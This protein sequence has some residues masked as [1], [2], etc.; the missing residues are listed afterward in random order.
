MSFFASTPKQILSGR[1]SARSR[2]L[3]RLEALE[4]RV[5]PWATSGNL[6]PTPSLITLSF[7]PD[8]TDLGGMPS[9]LFSSMNAR[10]GSPTAWQAQILKAAQVWAKNTNINFAV[11]SDNGAPLGSGAYQ[12]GDPGFGDIRIGGYNFENSSLAMAYSPPPINNYSIAGDIQFNTGQV[13]NIGATYDLFT[14]AMHEFGH[15]LTMSHSSVLTASEYLAY[16]SV[17]TGLDWDDI[18]GIRSAYSANQPR[19]HDYNDTY[20]NNNSFWT[21]T[22]VTQHLQSDLTLLRHDR[23]ITTTSDVDYFKITA[24]SWFGS[25]VQ[26]SAQSNG[27][28]L[29]APNIWVYNSS[30]Q[31][32]GYASG[33]GQYGTT[34]TVT[35][36]NQISAGQVIYVKVDGSDSTPFGTGKYAL[37]M[38]W[39]SAPLPTQAPPV[40]TMANG[41]PLSGGGGIA[42]ANSQEIVVAAPGGMEFSLNESSQ[43][44]AMDRQGNYVVTWSARNTQTG[45]R[46]II[47][48][49]LDAAGNPRR[50]II[51]V[52]SSNSGAQMYPAVAMTDSGEFLITWAAAE[53]GGGGWDIWARRF[54][55]AGNPLGTDFQVNEFTSGDQLYPT[56]AINAPGDFVITWSSQQQDGSGWGI[57]GR[58]YTDAVPGREY[59]VNSTKWSDQKWSRVAMDAAGNFVVTW[60]SQQS[61][62]G[63]DVYA[64]GF[65]PTGL[66]LTTEFRVNQ[67]TSDDQ[68]YSALAMDPSGAF[69]V[70][71]QSHGQDGDDW[72]IYARSF[73]ALGAAATDEFRVNTTVLGDQIDATVAMSQE[74]DF[75][76]AWSGDREGGPLKTPLHHGQSSGSG[77]SGSGSSGSGSSGSGN[78]GSDGSGSGSSGSG[79]SGPGS[80]GPS[81]YTVVE[82]L[83]AVYAQQY[84]HGEAVGEEFRVN[85]SA[86]GDHRNASAAMN[87]MGVIAV[88]WGGASISG[89]TF[90]M[91]QM[92]AVGAEEMHGFEEHPME[93]KLLRASDP[94]SAVALAV[95]I[96][97]SCTPTHLV[98][99]LTPS[100]TVASTHGEIPGRYQQSAIPA[101]PQASYW[102]LGRSSGMD[103][104][105]LPEAESHA[106]SHELLPTATEPVVAPGEAFNEGT[107]PPAPPAVAGPSE[108]IVSALPDSGEAVTTLHSAS[109][110]YTFFALAG[111]VAPF[112]WRRA[113]RKRD[114]NNRAPQT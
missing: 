10:F 21:A 71:W 66:P 114:R 85:T 60:S 87:S 49:L 4:S 25:T 16:T 48:L 83:W 47:A 2:F 59:R 15:A 78:S 52:S 84:R 90:T 82:S 11:V 5:V 29:L 80:S 22:D 88:A 7:V 26:F 12:Q 93:K 55:A 103:G 19:S 33:A 72:D 98:Q 8:G 109:G 51:T 99:P 42:N 18:F 96:P 75:I 35:L 70:A 100:S 36:T 62:N 65:G 45:E 57:Y 113:E 53:P 89:Q 92:Y 74:G 44:V 102:Q 17:K 13:F 6:W 101:M 27:L 79:N 50:D 37:A 95:T 1:W 64:R 94:P 68:Q 28:S 30:F 91:A 32:I 110:C 9:N 23:D 43:S 104:T 69:V 24:P 20:G 111:V 56:A 41:T 97:H 31:Q 61:G 107:I 63:W 38:R 77:S 46:F 14:V 39:A 106:P 105:E 58:S 54:D 73:A 3:P 81:S 86:G 67:Y 34:V 76:I 108:E 112:G 40:T